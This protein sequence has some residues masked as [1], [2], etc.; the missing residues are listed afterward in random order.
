VSDVPTELAEVVVGALFVATGFVASAAAL[1]ARPRADRAALCFG[2]FALLYGL[3]L[4]A[5]SSLVGIATGVPA[6]FFNY[7]DAFITY[8]ILVPAGLFV[9]TFTGPGWHRLVRRSW[10]LACVYAVVAVASDLAQRQPYASGWL[11]APVVLT[12]LAI[13]I[14]HL[15]A[16]ARGRRWSIE[17]RV[18]IVTL[19]IFT[20]IVIFETLSEQGLFGLTFDIEPFAMLLFTAALGWFVLT[21]AREQTTRFAA[22]SRELQLARDIQRSLL[23]SRM[24]AAPGLRIHGTYLPMSAVAG[25]FY[26]VTAL[27]DGC[28]AVMVADVSGHGVPAALVASM[29]KV[30]FAAESERNDQPGQMLA[31]VNR[32]LTGKFERAYVTACCVVIDRAGETLAYAC[33]GHPPPLLRRRNGSIERLREGGVALAL[34][35]VAEYR[36]AEV[37]FRT[38]DCLLLFTDGLLEAERRDDEFFGDAELE[39][40]VSELPATADASDRIMRAHRDWIG[41][42]APL[43]DDVTLVVA[44]CVEGDG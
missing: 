18:V 13:Q 12:M 40:V 38:G 24:P 36:T 44:E 20:F 3:R 41:S 17:L 9:E 42:E 7:V 4:A 14:P 23:P 32:T 25:D 19:V 27:A 8:T 6:P 11:N 26:D 28:I 16:L 21:R 43:S 1:S 2:V 35:P 29:V 5:K 30:A 31:G 22:L 39:R 15:V 34:R 37:P 33:A 10:H